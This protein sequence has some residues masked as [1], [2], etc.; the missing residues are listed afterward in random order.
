MA[1]YQGKYF[2]VEM[3]RP[4]R[5]VKPAQGLMLPF[6]QVVLFR[7]A[8]PLPGRMLGG[9]SAGNKGETEQRT[10]RKEPL[11]VSWKHAMSKNS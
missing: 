1:T 8:P 7:F 9:A 5:E 6:E 3:V 10:P 4:R 11:E 2:P